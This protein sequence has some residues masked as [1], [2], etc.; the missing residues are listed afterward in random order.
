[1]VNRK[2]ILIVLVIITAGLFSSCSLFDSEEKQVKK[3][4]KLLAERVEKKGE[5]P[6]VKMAL[7]VKSIGELFADMTI[8]EDDV[9]DLS[10]EYRPENM[11]SLFAGISAQFNNLSLKFYDI[12]V[13]FAEE[14]VALAT[15]T[16]ALEGVSKLEGA[17]NATHEIEVELE[18][19]DGD[20]YF[21]RMSMLD[22]LEK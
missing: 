6:V 16:A 10:G 1:M 5:E 9:Y 7:R 22:V 13:K 19:I 21:T 4:F 11:T 12:E 14:S 3:V 17:F 18:K 15:M 2:N 8:I 20:W